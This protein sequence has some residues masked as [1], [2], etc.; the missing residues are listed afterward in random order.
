MLPS[1]PKGGRKKADTT[2]DAEEGWKEGAVVVRKASR[3]EWK[4]R[5]ALNHTTVCMDSF[6]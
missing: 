5:E 4:D 6:V 3:I 2:N 1:R